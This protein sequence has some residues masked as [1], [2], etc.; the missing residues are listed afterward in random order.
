MT[1]VGDDDAGAA[2]DLSGLALSVDFLALFSI[3]VSRPKPRRATH[4]ETG[5]LS[6]D[7]GVR[8]FDELDVVLGTESLDELEVL[9]YKQSA[10]V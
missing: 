4:G 8:D 2:N 10:H 1:V 3:L 9:G 7:L 6:E 5:P